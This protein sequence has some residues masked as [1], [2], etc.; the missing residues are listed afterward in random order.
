MSYLFLVSPDVVGIGSIIFYIA[1]TFLIGH[2]KTQWRITCTYVPGYSSLHVKTEPK[3]HIFRVGNPRY[4]KQ[5]KQ[6]HCQHTAVWNTWGFP[7]SNC[8]FLVLFLRANS[9]SLARTCK[10]TGAG[11]SISSRATQGHSSLVSRSSPLPS[12]LSWIK[13]KRHDPNEGK[14]PLPKPAAITSC[15][16]L[17]P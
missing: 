12:S 8:A 14:H 1:I 7:R 15:V 9:N 13:C 3:T 6:Q 4:F 16:P 10:F 11:P 2:A 5:G 17:L